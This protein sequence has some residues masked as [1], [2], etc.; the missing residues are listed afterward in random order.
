MANNKDS[1]GENWV[2]QE[3]QLLS[4]GIEDWQPNVSVGL[5]QLRAKVSVPASNL[6]W[7][8]ASLA[9]VVFCMLFAAGLPSPKALA[10]R[11]RVFHGG[12][13]EPGADKSCWS[14]SQTTGQP[15]ASSRIC[16]KRCQQQ[17]SQAF[18]LKGQSRIGKLS[19]Q[20][21]VRVVRLKFRGLWNFRK[22]MKLRAWQWSEF[23]WMTMAGNP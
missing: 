12:V 10:H 19:G 9:A 8:M 14:R 11:S 16:V 23:R 4:G 20:R 21:G 18:G 15:C 3:L 5:A 22:N 6:R 1:F 2:S 13:A 17:G 7:K